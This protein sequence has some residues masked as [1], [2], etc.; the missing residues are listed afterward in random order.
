[1][2]RVKVRDKFLMSTK[3]HIF[4]NIY[5]LR[6][7]SSEDMSL[8]P[9]EVAA[10]IHA[11]KLMPIFLQIEGLAQDKTR[12]Q[13]P[14]DIFET[15]PKSVASIA[16]IP[17]VSRS[18]SSRRAQAKR[19]STVFTVWI[20]AGCTAGKYRRQSRPSKQLRRDDQQSVHCRPC[21][22]KHDQVG[23]PSRTSVTVTTRKA[24]WKMQALNHRQLVE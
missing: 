5:F 8:W 15:I 9:Q 11:T 10:T 14:D 24:V 1:M 19:P 21:K 4:I 20:C 16:N 2:H 23:N 17:R 22:H 7:D 3:I 18:A 6:F 12:Q 13:H